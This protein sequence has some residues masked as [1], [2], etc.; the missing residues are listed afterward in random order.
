VNFPK[1]SIAW[2]NLIIGSPLR[3][4][5]TAAF[6]PAKRQAQALSAAPDEAYKVTWHNAASL[7]IHKQ[8]MAENQL[9]IAWSFIKLKTLGNLITCKNLTQTVCG[10]THK[11]FSFEKAKQIPTGEASKNQTAFLG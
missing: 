11:R 4:H 3:F 9:L 7:F 10:K 5:K 8:N 6:C 2:Q 1:Q